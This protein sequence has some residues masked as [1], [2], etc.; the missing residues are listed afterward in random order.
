MHK[1]HETCRKDHERGK[2]NTQ[3]RL[4]K[5]NLNK[6]KIRKMSNKFI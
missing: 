4:L 1:T 2:N 5:W 3:K 6:F